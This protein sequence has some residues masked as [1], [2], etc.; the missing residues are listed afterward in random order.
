MPHV[1]LWWYGFA[2][3]ASAAAAAC[4]VCISSKV[5]VLGPTARPIGGAAGV[6][7]FARCAACR[8]SADST[9]QTSADSVDMWMSH[10]RAVWFCVSVACC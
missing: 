1:Y 2:R 8:L 7:C 10:G 4:Q 3:A 5:D 6:C 9:G